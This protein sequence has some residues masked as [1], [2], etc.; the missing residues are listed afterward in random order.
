MNFVIASGLEFHVVNSLSSAIAFLS[1][2]ICSVQHEQFME[3][4]WIK[5]VSAMNTF[6]SGSIVDIKNWQLWRK[7]SYSS[8]I[9]TKKTKNNNIHKSEDQEISKTN[10]VWGCTEQFNFIL[11]VFFLTACY[12]NNESNL[13]SDLIFC[14]I[15]C[16]DNRLTKW[17]LELRF[18]EYCH[19]FPLKN[20]SRVVNCMDK[21]QQPLQKSEM[22]ILCMEN[23]L[24]VLNID[25]I[26]DNSNFKYLDQVHFPV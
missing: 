16:A 14:N 10:N 8:C 18:Y 26:Y 20:K 23:L 11:Y 13:C 1:K 7:L 4:V 5:N 22:N 19:F 6:M 25:K 24:N 12:W 15:L 17:L 9:T 3:E 21:N 2:A